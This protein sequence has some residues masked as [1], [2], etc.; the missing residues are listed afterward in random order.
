MIAQITMIL[1][2]DPV[3]AG[4]GPDGEFGD[5]AFVACMLLAAELHGIAFCHHCDCAATSAERFSPICLNLLI[6]PVGR[7]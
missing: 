6:G 5:T 3:H 1:S 2:F 7:Y 4:R